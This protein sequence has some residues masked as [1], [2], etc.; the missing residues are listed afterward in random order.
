MTPRTRRWTDALAGPGLAEARRLLGLFG[1]PFSDLRRSRRWIDVAC[2]KYAP[3]L[4]GH[5]TATTRAST[6]T[7]TAA[8]KAHIAGLLGAIDADAAAA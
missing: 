4:R 3:S 5:C 7:L 6:A 2:V 1:H 8:E